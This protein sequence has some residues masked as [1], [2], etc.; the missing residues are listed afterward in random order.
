MYSQIYKDDYSLFDY[1]TQSK[2]EIFAAWDSHDAIMFQ[3]PTGT[4]K[5][6]LFTSVIRDIMRWG[7]ETGER[8]KIIV[9]AHRKELID[10]I[11][12]S[13][14][15]YEISHGIVAGGRSRD[16]QQR[17][18]VASI[19]TLAQSSQKQKYIDLEANF[20]IIDE[21]HHSI[22]PS[23][24]R[25]WEFYPNAK[26]LGVTATPWSMKRSG[27][28][29]LYGDIILSL[30][31]REFIRR[32]R[33]SPF[34]YYS[35]KNSNPIYTQV[36]EIHEFDK[37]GDF[38]RNALER[39]FDK[40]A[41]RAQLLDSYLEYAKG[42]KGIIYSICRAHSKHI[43]EEYA[44]AGVR[45]TDIDGDTPKEE[46]EQ[47]VN[48][49]KEGKLDI[50]V[51][52]D[53]FSEGFDCPDIEFIQLARPTRSLVKYIQQVGR[54][55]RVSKYKERCII[56]DNVGA[57]HDFGLP[58]V[59]R[60]WRSHFLGIK[61]KHQVSFNEDSDEETKEK[62]EREVNMREG[63]ELMVRIYNE[64]DKEYEKDTSPSEE[65]TDDDLEKIILENKKK[66]MKAYGK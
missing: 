35:I 32:K 65:Q 25:L 6:R 58:D 26:F 56:L 16:L 45:I 61:K 24:Q 22:A 50:I 28:S 15:R 36:H 54:G 2:K 53:I 64:A 11:D 57:L 48:D 13:L 23:Y 8:I 14:K 43:C 31:P 3:M 49:F 29:H 33:L 1:Q 18:L 9:V 62:T 63:H 60:E 37:D 41:I 52:V 59:D 12:A 10:Q 17:V 38:T 7:D 27:F 40:V 51:N 20:V 30:Q 34:D 46:R 5:T 19:Q 44:A 55:L 42:K 66:F 21:A 47:K 39:E 4:G